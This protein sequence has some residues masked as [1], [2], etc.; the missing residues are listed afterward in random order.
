MYFE[1]LKQEL[2][3]L[4]SKEESTTSL[5]S[6]LELWKIQSECEV[7][8]EELLPL[9]KEL[10]DGSGRSAAAQTIRHPQTFG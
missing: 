7:T 5:C 2:M 4:D 10:P 8:L 9:L 6:P 3:R 1:A